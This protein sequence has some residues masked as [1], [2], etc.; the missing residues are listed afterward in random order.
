MDILVLCTVTVEGMK[1]GRLE[2]K[3]SEVELITRSSLIFS[4]LVGKN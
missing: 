2:E 3:E 4:N 1:I